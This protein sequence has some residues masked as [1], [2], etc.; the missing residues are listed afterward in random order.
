MIDHDFGSFLRH[1]KTALMFVAHIAT[2]DISS[3][4]QW[5]ATIRT[6]TIAAAVKLDAV[7]DVM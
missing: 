2:I 6:R 1:M 7:C 5:T 3:G 4:R